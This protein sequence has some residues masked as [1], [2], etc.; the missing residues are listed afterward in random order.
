[1]ADKSENISG[2]EQLARWVEGDP[3]HRGTVSGG[4]CCPDFSCCQPQLLAD[5][6]TRKAFAVASE[7]GRNRFLGA[8]LGAAIAAMGKGDE[9]YI[10][11][12]EPAS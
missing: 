8:F 4:E 1:M 9:V 12:K 5:E 2:E 10:A 6:E 11:G 3:V 7:S